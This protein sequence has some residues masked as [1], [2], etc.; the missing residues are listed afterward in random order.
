MFDGF[1]MG[2]FPLVGPNALNDLL[3]DQIAV[4]PTIKDKW[5]GVIMAVFLIGAATGG[6]LFGWLGDRIGRVRAMSLSIFTYAI[7]AN[8]DQLPFPATRIA[9]LWQAADGRK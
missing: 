2:M 1:E 4:D 7:L 6:I 5:F 3:R 9:Y 8:C